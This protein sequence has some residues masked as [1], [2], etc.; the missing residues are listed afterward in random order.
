[1][2]LPVR[3]TITHLGLE[4]AMRASMGAGPI[5]R[6]NESLARRPFCESSKRTVTVGSPGHTC[7]VSRL[8]SG[9]KPGWKPL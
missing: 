8:S 5:V 1:M 2:P 7:E 9:S 4:P 6:S 3:C